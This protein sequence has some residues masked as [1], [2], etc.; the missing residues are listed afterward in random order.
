[1]EACFPD[2]LSLTFIE[3]IKLKIEYKVKFKYNLRVTQ[4]LLKISKDCYKLLS[5]IIKDNVD[6]KNELLNNSY[7]FFYHLGYI[8]AANHCF[9]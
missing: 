7:Y 1:M 8:K 6:N 9:N 2:E 4:E 5:F 3:H